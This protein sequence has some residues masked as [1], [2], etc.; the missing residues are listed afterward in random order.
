MN[1]NILD[2]YRLLQELAWHFGNRG[3]D[4]QC[5]EDLSLVEFMA[6]K[7]IYEKK[8]T[9]I[10]DIGVALNFSKSGA[11]RIV[12]RLENKGY[13]VRQRSPVDGRICCVNITEDG[14]EAIGRITDKNASDLGEALSDLEPEKID[15]IR[16]AL[17]I[18]ANAIKR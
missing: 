11:T 9:S 3:F 12:D 6:L 15:Q 5:C 4:G 18:L 10:Q 16:E 13:L 8:D 17:Q 14:S 1:D 7:T 2:I